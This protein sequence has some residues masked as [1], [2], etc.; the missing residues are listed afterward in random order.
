MAW[1]TA[2][3]VT[4][5]SIVLATAINRMLQRCISSLLN[6]ADGEERAISGFYT[7]AILDRLLA[8]SVVMY[9]RMRSVFVFD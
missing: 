7:A 9:E 1:K 4:I 2:L 3:S 5:C 8:L 6:F